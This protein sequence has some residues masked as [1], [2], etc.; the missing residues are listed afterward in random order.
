MCTCIKDINCIILYFL[1]IFCSLVRNGNIKRPGFSTLQATKISSNFPQLKKPNKI[2][3]TRE[4]CD[5]FE[6]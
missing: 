1:K 5:L 4:Y 2:R 3:N 6:F